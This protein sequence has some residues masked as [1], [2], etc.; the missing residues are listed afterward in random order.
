MNDIDVESKEWWEVVEEYFGK[1]LEQNLAQHKAYEKSFKYKLEI[2]QKKIPE[3][4]YESPTSIETFNQD[5]EI[6][7]W[8]D[9]KDEEEEVQ[10]KKP[11][12][13]RGGGQ[14]KKKPQ[15]I[16]DQEQMET[17]LATKVEQSNM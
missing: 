3:F 16:Q 7:T 5:E 1:E 15:T 17:I 11:H 9:R 12:E 13:L 2:Y 4:I 14:G 10:T 6:E 8:P